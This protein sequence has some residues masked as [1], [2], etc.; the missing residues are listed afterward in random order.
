M[1][2]ILLSTLL[3]FGIIKETHFIVLNAH[4]EEWTAGAKGSGSGVEY[5]LKTVITTSDA[6]KF[7][8]LWTDNKVI[9]LIVVKGKVYDPKASIAKNDTVMLR[10]SHKNN[11]KAIPVKPPVAYKGAALISYTVNGAKHYYTVTKIQK[12]QSLPHP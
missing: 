11:S 5:Y 3:C 12:K 8:S 9:P 6:I 2:Y 10:A 4:Y 7:D 1:K